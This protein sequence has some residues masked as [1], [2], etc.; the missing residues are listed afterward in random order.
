[1]TRSK[2]KRKP[3][4]LSP[5]LELLE[6]RLTLTIEAIPPIFVGTGPGS[7]ET[8]ISLVWQRPAASSETSYQLQRSLDGR[9]W[10]ND[11]EIWKEVDLDPN[12]TT[13][14]LL[15]QPDREVYYRVRGKSSTEEGPWSP[16]SNLRQ[17]RIALPLSTTITYSPSKT[18]TLH[19]PD[20]VND[21]RYGGAPTYTIYRRSSTL[22]TWTQISDTNTPIS[23]GNSDFVIDFVDTEIGSLPDGTY[24]YLI[25]Q[26]LNNSVQ[27]QVTQFTSRISVAFNTPLPTRGKI[28]LVVD[29]DLYLESNGIDIKP[30]G[31]AN[32]LTRLS[33]DLL[34]DGWKEVIDVPVDLTVASTPQAVRQMIIDAYNSHSDLRAVILIGKIPV[35]FAGNYDPDGHGSRPVSTDAYYGDIDLLDGQGNQVW[36]GTE[37]VIRQIQIPDA[38]GPII[39]LAVGRIDFSGLTTQ[40]FDAASNS[41]RGFPLTNETPDATYV[42]LTKNYLDKDHFYRSGIITPQ[43]KAYIDNRLGFRPNFTG[44]NNFPTLFGEDH[45]YVA[46]YDGGTEAGTDED[47]W[48]KHLQ[49]SSYLWAQ[50]SSFGTTITNS[51]NVRVG[52]RLFPTNPV[53]KYEPGYQFAY[54]P[55]NSVFNY[56]TGSYLWEWHYPNNFLQSMLAASGSALVAFW[57]NGA[58]A[59]NPLHAMASGDT[60]G[61]TY[62]SSQNE[63]AMGFSFDSGSFTDADSLYQSLL[64]DPTLRL[65]VVA[66]PT[67]AKIIKDY[68]TNQYEL[69]WTA[70]ADA[71]VEKYSI[72]EE[73]N[74]GVW[75]FLQD[76]PVQSGVSQYS[77]TVPLVKSDLQFMV[78]AVKTEATPASGQYANASQGIYA[79]FADFN[80]D[81]LADPL[82]FEVLRTE[83]LLP[84][85][86]PASD[87]NGDGIVDL[88]DYVLFTQN[89]LGTTPFSNHISIGDY[90]LNGIVD[91]VDY[92]VWKDAFGSTLTLF[93][94]GNDNDVID[95]ADYTVWKDHFGDLVPGATQFVQAW[96]VSLSGAPC[97][98][99]VSIG[100]PTATEVP[101]SFADIDGSGEQLRRVPVSIPDQV[102][103]TFSEEVMVVPED[104]ILI[105]LRNP[106][107][108]SV[109][110]FTYDM[111]TRTATWTLSAPLDS[112]QYLIWLSDDV[113]DLDHNQLDGEWTNPTNLSDA[114]GTKSVFPSGNGVAGGDFGFVFTVLAGDVDGDN[115]VDIDD[116]NFILGALGQAASGMAEGDLDGNGVVNNLDKDIVDSLIGTDFTGLVVASDFNGDWSVD[117]GDLGIWSQNNGNNGGH[118]QGDANGDGVVNNDDLDY[119]F[120]QLGIVI[121]T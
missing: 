50:L 81:G 38:S 52:D 87:A 44:V 64:G 103:I 10:P 2:T 31:I 30:N 8:R 67:N 45:I 91:T 42:R 29:Q 86:H 117:Y 108:I 79:K 14:G 26:R 75:S 101:Y 96:P 83:F 71:A 43:E 55:V 49:S 6:P 68:T 41:F 53:P 84:L 13:Q 57:G 98:E 25:L 78:R 99:A 73:L 62:N 3:A 116:Q 60:V 80:G 1:M 72:Y 92:T 70:S 66:P 119:W 88:D 85:A 47:R 118:S 12:S 24:E 105:G 93:A 20:R 113:I 63:F 5:T 74:P 18:L 110:D 21:H 32:E 65:D 36:N 9:S 89:L 95:A 59:N 104:L 35:Y 100:R 115:I 37:T 90:N 77:W 54:Q 17:D 121:S 106:N 109:T 19:W 107:P 76:V 16:P 51:S 34:G 27:N 111:D 102:S 23:D 28:A 112:D 33:R 114:A 69:H 40:V 7:N 97:V 58:F 46:G 22:E 39:E 82:D 61:S 48:F 15:V 120:Q 94:D 4:I 11:T 56:V